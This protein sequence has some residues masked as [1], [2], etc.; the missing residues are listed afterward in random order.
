M[1]PQS[2]CASNY[3]RKKIIIMF[4]TVSWLQG[5]HI[6]L[7]SKALYSIWTDTNFWW[8]GCSHVG[9]WTASEQSKSTDRIV[10]CLASKKSCHMEESWD[11]FNVGNS[12]R[13]WTVRP[14]F[15]RPLSSRMWWGKQ[16][17]SCKMKWHM[18]QASFIFLP[19]AAKKCT[20]SEVTHISL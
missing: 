13:A 7:Q 8:L 3:K 15:T 10:S 9:S 12:S 20:L 1:L 11:T 16:S 5:F 14:T 19:K 2:L 17:L 6:Q 18:Y 4:L